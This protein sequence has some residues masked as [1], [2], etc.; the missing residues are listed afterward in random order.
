MYD[1]GDDTSITS[2]DVHNALPF[3]PDENPSKIM[4]FFVQDNEEDAYALVQSCQTSNHYHDSILFQRW[5]K[6]FIGRVQYFEPMLHLV[7]VDSF[8]CCIFVIEE[9]H[10]IEEMV[11]KQVFKAGITV[12]TPRKTHWLGLFNV[13]DAGKD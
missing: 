12:V 1:V 3:H 8:G 7:P 10:T 9:D 5:T 11:P 6:E 2:D 4:Y 13:N